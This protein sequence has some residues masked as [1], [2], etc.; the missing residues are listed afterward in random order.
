MR[1]SKADWYFREIVLHLG[2]KKPVAHHDDY[3]DTSGGG[4]FTLLYH[5]QEKT[6]SWTISSSALQG[7]QHSHENIKVTIADLEGQR[8]PTKRVII[9][10]SRFRQFI[11]RGWRMPHFDHINA[12]GGGYVHIALKQSNLIIRII[13]ISPISLFSRPGTSTPARAAKYTADRLKCSAQQRQKSEIS[14]LSKWRKQSKNWMAWLV[15]TASWYIT[16][17][18]QTCRIFT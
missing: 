6:D 3:F 18:S 4:Y 15:V 9:T 11:S 13:I 12:F 5:Y 14:S 2:G 8:G 7:H 10:R 16:K 17:T 1:F